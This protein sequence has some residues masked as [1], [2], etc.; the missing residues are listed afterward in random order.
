MVY[1]QFERLNIELY[2]RESLSP[3]VRASDNLM[4]IYFRREVYFSQ[5][6]VLDFSGRFIQRALLRRMY[7]P[8]MQKTFIPITEMKTCYPQAG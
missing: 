1:P 8:C 3:L 5:Q 4:S 6:S 7:A 2:T